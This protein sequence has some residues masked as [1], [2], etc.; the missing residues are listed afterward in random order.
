MEMELLKKLKTGFERS[1][2]I[3]MGYYREEYKH[4]AAKE[5]ECT[6]KGI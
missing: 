2:L 6:E 5:I 1:D 4:V 3:V